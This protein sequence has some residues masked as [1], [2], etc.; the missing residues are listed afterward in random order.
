MSF[1]KSS[2][3]RVRCQAR[4]IWITQSRMSTY[5]NSSREMILNTPLRIVCSFKAQVQ[6]TC[7][8]SIS[9]QIK[10]LRRQLNKVEGTRS[11]LLISVQPRSWREQ[12][13]RLTCTRLRLSRPIPMQRGLLSKG[14]LNHQ[15]QLWSEIQREA[16]LGL[17]MK[18]C[19]EQRDPQATLGS[20]RIS[21]Q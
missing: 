2:N 5:T 7:N 17:R 6:S 3:W 20:F 19:W 9:F 11:S 4:P 16:W 8:T 12:S 1:L 10:F 13:S 15:E 14:V 18:T 21:A